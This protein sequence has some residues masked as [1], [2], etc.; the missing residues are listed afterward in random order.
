MRAR[1]HFLQNIERICQIVGDLVVGGQTRGNFS[2]TEMLPQPFHPS[3]HAEDF[4]LPRLTIHLGY[5]G[6]LRGWDFLD[7]LHVNEWNVS[8]MQNTVLPVSR[9]YVPFLPLPRSVPDLAEGP[10]L[11]CFLQWS[12]GQV[13]VC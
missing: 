3:H 5:T 12:N 13:G 1:I 7:I 11:Q 4:C 8:S 2:F 9:T 6:H 10:S